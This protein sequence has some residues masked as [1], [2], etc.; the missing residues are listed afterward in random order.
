M[1]LIDIAMLDFEILKFKP[2]ILTASALYLVI[3]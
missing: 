2:R 3:G 1:Q